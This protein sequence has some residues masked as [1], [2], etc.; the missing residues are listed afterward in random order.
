MIEKMAELVFVSFS[1]R[2]F[3]TIFS[4]GY[5]KTS[6]VDNVDCPRFFLLFALRDINLKP[7]KQ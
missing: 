4:I 1:M 5:A 6:S 3:F 2:A 7:I